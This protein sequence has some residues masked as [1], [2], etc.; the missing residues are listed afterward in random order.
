MRNHFTLIAS[1]VAAQH[2][3]SEATTGPTD[4]ARNTVV[5]REPGAFCGWPANEGAW[6]WGNE[7]LV[8]FEVRPYK[9]STNGHSAGRPA[10]KMFA[11]SRDGGET[12]QAE[13]ATYDFRK[14]PES[15]PAPMD[16][17]AEGF[18]L[19][20]RRE[21]LYYS[22]DRGHTWRGPYALR[23]EG[24]ASVVGAR[25]DYLVEGPRSCKILLSAERTQYQA[26]RSLVA[27]TEDGGLT[28]RFVSWL[29]PAPPLAGK[30]PG[31]TF[32]IMPSTA[33]LA[34]G[35]LITALRQRHLAR[36]WIDIAKSSDGGASWEVIATPVRGAWNP[37]SLIALID[38]R[39]CLTYGDRRRPF[40]IRAVLSDTGGA[41]W[42]KPR[43][44]RQDGRTWDLGYVQSVQRPD[45][46][47]VSV[48]YY[49]TAQH[50]EQF[51]G[52]TIWRP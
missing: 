14:K 46:L 1:L 37:A 35:T 17:Q 42:S 34:D 27:Q 6:I 30:R 8:G 4:G 25:T 41:R 12:W 9:P 23:I 10:R 33:R 40:G 45:G 51:I 7:I 32:S 5:Y 47:V 48:Y 15:L 38:G 20:C 21:K 26:G 49:T 2:A 28:F 36:K 43:I 22:H 18:A 16:F 13:A 19:K 24:L 52:C 29:S 3:A 50:P 31:H 44:L 39:L 11:R